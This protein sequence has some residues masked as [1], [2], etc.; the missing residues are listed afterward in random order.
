MK[1]ENS[2]QTAVA[3]KPDARDLIDCQLAEWRDRHEKYLT[4]YVSA[5]ETERDSRA[6]AACE[7]LVCIREL[8]RLR[9]RLCG[10]KP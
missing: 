6:N 1:P 8:R 10:L 3:A 4:A 9:D 5:P 2:E 7:L